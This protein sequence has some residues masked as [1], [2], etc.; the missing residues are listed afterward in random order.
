MAY[1]NKAHAPSYCLPAKVMGYAVHIK[2]LAIGLWLS[3]TITQVLD[4]LTTPYKSYTI[5]EYLVT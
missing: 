2:F 4:D 1:P 3:F 5:K